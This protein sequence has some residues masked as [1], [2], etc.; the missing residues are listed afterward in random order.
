[1]C[2][3]GAR[4]HNLLLLGAAFI[5]IIVGASTFRPYSSDL[6]DDSTH[7]DTEIDYKKVHTLSEMAHGTFKEFKKG[8]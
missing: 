5:L 7:V 1:M 2:Q 4:T 8:V 6:N 3:I